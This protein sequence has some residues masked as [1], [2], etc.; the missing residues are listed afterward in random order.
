MPRTRFPPLLTDLFPQASPRELLFPT[1]PALGSNT[2]VVEALD[3][4]PH[5]FMP[6]QGRA[7][8]LRGGF[9]AILLALIGSPAFVAQE[10]G[11]QWQVEVWVMGGAAP[12]P[13]NW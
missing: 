4:G 5:T 3:P 6:P 11:I 10:D 7:S 9:N 8:L 12:N 13:M 2:T 1:P